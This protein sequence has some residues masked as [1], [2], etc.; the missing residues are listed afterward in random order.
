MAVAVLGL[1]FATTLFFSQ[2]RYRHPPPSSLSF[3]ILSCPLPPLWVQFPF[4]VASCL[5]LFPLKSGNNLMFPGDSLRWRMVKI[6]EFYPK[7]IL[8]TQQEWVKL[9]NFRSDT[10]WGK[11]VLFCPRWTK[12]LN[13]HMQLLTFQRVQIIDRDGL[14]WCDSSENL[15]FGCV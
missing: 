10:A 12:N 5:W 1:K 13:T 9:S 8:V 3:S 6:S 2:L 15:L 7:N 11:R 4:E 14:P